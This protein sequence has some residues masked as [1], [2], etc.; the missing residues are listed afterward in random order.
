MIL[1]FLPHILIGI[2]VILFLVIIASGYVKAPPD[3]AYIISGLHKEP[4]ILVG[5]A[6]IKVP[7][8][9]RLDKLSLGAIQIDVKTG[10]AVPT[11][12]YINVRVDSTV[13]VRVGQTPEM[14]TLAAWSAGIPR[15]LSCVPSARGWCSLP[16]RDSCRRCTCAEST[17]G[18][19]SSCLAGVRRV[20]CSR[21][22]G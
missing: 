20:A 6:G 9:E 2:A 21:P 7:F 18:R 19:A 15:C 13:S 10:S 5:K 4:R 8:F 16:R 11:A 1:T 22:Q 12:E 3:I 14:I 17:Y